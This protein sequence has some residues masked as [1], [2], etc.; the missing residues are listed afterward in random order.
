MPGSL[1]RQRPLVSGGAVAAALVAQQLRR[2]APPA[3]GA[4]GAGQGLSSLP[5]LCRSPERSLGRCSRAP[6][7]RGLG[8]PSPAQVPTQ[9]PTLRAS[10]SVIAKWGQ[11]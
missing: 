5:R 4:A 9:K 3:G 1:S 10:V 2:D 7:G 11:K 6:L 8:G